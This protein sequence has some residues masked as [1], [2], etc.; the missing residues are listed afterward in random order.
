MSQLVVRSPNYGCLDPEGVHLCAQASVC[1]GS[2]D[3]ALLL[4]NSLRMNVGWQQLRP[5]T[6][7]GL[8][9]RTALQ[10]P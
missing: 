10:F 7:L 3:Q 9:V 8:Q 2:R 5:C 1:P 6:H 4:E